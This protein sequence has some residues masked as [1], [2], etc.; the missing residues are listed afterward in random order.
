MW[1]KSR[2]LAGPFIIVGTSTAGLILLTDQLHSFLSSAILDHGTSNLRASLRGFPFCYS[3]DRQVLNMSPPQLP[4]LYFSVLM[5]AHLLDH[6]IFSSR[7]YT[8]KTKWI[9]FGVCAFAIVGTF[10]WFKGLAF[11]IMGPI[12]EHKGLLWRKVSS[13]P[14]ILSVHH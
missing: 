11:G 3:C 6:F 8:T 9:V 2:S 4:T 5:L 7:R 1:G 12:S 13:I 14:M 10:W